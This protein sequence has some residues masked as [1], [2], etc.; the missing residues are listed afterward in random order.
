MGYKSKTQKLKKM[1][2][3]IIQ[4][5]WF[6]SNKLKLFVSNL[7]TVQHDVDFDDGPSLEVVNGVSQLLHRLGKTCH[8]GVS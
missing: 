2:Y 8:D 7:V 1:F 6:Q 3:I 4:Y 5:S